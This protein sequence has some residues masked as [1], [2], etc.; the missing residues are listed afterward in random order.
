MFCVFLTE[1]T[2]ELKSG[3]DF[4]D[5]NGDGGIDVQ[6]AQIM[7]DYANQGPAGQAAPASGSVPVL[8]GMLMDPNALIWDYLPN[9]TMIVLTLIFLGVMRRFQCKY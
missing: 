9:I 4:I 1:C 7:A 3:F 6:E 2:S 8:F 5:T